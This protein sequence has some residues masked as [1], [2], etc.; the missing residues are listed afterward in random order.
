M[1]HLPPA[2][3]SLHAALRSGDISAASESLAQ[4]ADPN[5]PHP[6]AGRW[7]GPL[8]LAAQLGSAEGVALM[9]AAGAVPGAAEGRGELLAAIQADSAECAALLLQAGAR[10]DSAQ[11]G[12]PLLEAA[13]RP[14]PGIVRLLLD[15]GALLP[16]TPFN[17]PAKA[18]AAAAA[19]RQSSVGAA[20]ARAI[21]RAS[22][23]K[24]RPAAA[25]I[26]LW[27]AA[28][29]DDAPMARA[30]MDEGGC[31]IH[32]GAG[33]CSALSLAIRLGKMDMA[34]LLISGARQGALLAQSIERSCSKRMKTLSANSDTQVFL[35]RA[36]LVRASLP[37]LKEM[38]ILV[39]ATTRSPS[40]RAPGP[41]RSSRCRI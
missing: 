14:S 2:D 33:H 20:I 15:A 36:A 22:P 21:L 39:R 12:S 29:N 8:A 23:P 1:T 35:R 24:S 31:P 18:V 9:L 7:R 4:G 41:T 40:L 16:Q 10:P 37:S 38:A 3:S 28:D 13:R 5:G 26:G 6:N 25:A 30:L 11:L 17:S 34:E 27:T 32:R 19:L